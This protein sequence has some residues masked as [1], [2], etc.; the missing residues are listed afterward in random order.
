MSPQELAA[1][2]LL[3]TRQL[4]DTIDE[5]EPTFN[6]Y[7]TATEKATKALGGES[8]KWDEQDHEVE[9]IRLR[10]YAENIK[11]C[12]EFPKHL[13]CVSKILLFLKL[14]DHKSPRKIA[15]LLLKGVES[16]HPHTV[17]N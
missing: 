4:L 15:A 5:N 1:L 6:K 7:A 3:T 12:G 14:G 9:V 16:L 13:I 17:W 11:F 2:K 10:A 8:T